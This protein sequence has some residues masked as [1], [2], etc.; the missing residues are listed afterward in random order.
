MMSPLS[1]IWFQF[2]LCAILIGAAGY[3]LSL[4]GDVIAQRTGMSGSWIG[5][6]LLAT[7]TSLPE[8]AT[9]ISSVT[10]ANAPN[11]AVGDA[12]GSCVVNLVF[13]VVIDTL[14]R[15]EPLWPRAG[16]G[17]VLA[18]AF[19]V[20]MLGFTLVSLLMSQVTLPQT[21]ALNSVVTQL[22]FG[23]T[24]PVLLG[25]YLVAMRTVFAYEHEH[26]VA[27]TDTLD[28]QLPA[29]RTA[30]IRFALAACVVAGAG[31]WLPF[32]ATDLANAMAWNKSF[33]GSLFVALAT[34]LPELAVTLSA[35][36]IGAL[37]MAIGNL[38]GSNLFNV[39]IIAVDD[40]FYRPGVLLA[41][42]SSVHAVTAASAITM[43]GLALVGLFFKPGGRVLRAM[44]WI[45]LGLVCMYLLNTYVLFLFGE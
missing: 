37:E 27:Q 31:V 43:T 39:V 9:G 28:N 5:L 20:L 21:S 8:L 17:H 36:R 13:L 38:L 32:V 23:L 26:A 12:L 19:G 4:Y 10:L 25:L 1:V 2:A 22:G 42:V 45:S 33:V 44:S 30:L 15:K 14:I 3:Q 11:L 24:T 16:Q 40:L 34:S 7:V 6:A 18:A 29:L 35:L 41:N